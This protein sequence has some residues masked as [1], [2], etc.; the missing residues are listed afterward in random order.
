MVNKNVDSQLFI[1]KNE[2]KSLCKKMNLKKEEIS[3]IFISDIEKADAENDKM[4]NITI[5]GPEINI[6]AVISSLRKCRY[7]FNNL[8]L[9]NIRI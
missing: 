2:Y 8:S 6:E 5:S 7:Y 4:E 1:L 9:L 3:S